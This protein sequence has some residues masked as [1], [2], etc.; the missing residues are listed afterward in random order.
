MD[1]KA[2]YVRKF[3]HW[4]VSSSYGS[5]VVYENVYMSVDTQSLFGN[6]FDVFVR[7]FQG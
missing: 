7:R 4:T 1:S 2:G 6:V 3:F 5:R